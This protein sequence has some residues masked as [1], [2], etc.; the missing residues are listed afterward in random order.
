MPGRQKTCLGIETQP[1]VKKTENTGGANHQ[2][3]SSRHKT[4]QF[5]NCRLTLRAYD[6][7]TWMLDSHAFRLAV[8]ACAGRRGSASRPRLPLGTAGDIS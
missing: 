2:A 3:V 5:C 4:H 6:V 7:I 8:L 1:L